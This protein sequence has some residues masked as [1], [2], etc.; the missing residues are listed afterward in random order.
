MNGIPAVDGFA[1]KSSIEFGEPEDVLTLHR[2]LVHD[3]A[4]ARLD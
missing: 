3:V 4:D 2:H 1:L